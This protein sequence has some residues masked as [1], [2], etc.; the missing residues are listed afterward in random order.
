MYLESKKAIFVGV[1]RTGIQAVKERLMPYVT[2]EEYTEVLDY[3]SSEEKYG[4]PAMNRNFTF[5][6]VRN[7][8][9][10][11]VSIF[12]DIVQNKKELLEFTSVKTFED[13]C[14]AVTQNRF[15]KLHDLCHTQV[16]LLKPRNKFDPIKVD[17]TGR[18]ENLN[19]DFKTVC[20]TIVI[21]HKW[22]KLRNISRHFDYHVYYNSELKK[23]VGKF[24]QEDIDVYKYS[25]GK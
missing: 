3:Q 7:P 23:M 14:K 8:W 12:F 15:G 24:F 2:N 22:L 25:F 10:R 13:F 16:S 21:D 18:F 9:D 6:F 17:Y 20:D 11:M 1:P 4:K 5:S 19:R